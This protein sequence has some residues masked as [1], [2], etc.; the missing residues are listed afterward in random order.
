MYVYIYI[1]IYIFIYI[2]IYIY[3]YMYVCVSVC[4][5]VSVSVCVCGQIPQNG[6]SFAYL[7]FSIMLRIECGGFGVKRG[8]PFD[9]L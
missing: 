8:S 3:I 2:Y 1:H 7:C 9:A 5:S 6:T 4:V